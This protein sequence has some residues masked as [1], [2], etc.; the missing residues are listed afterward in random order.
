MLF[1][2]G[3]R[4]VCCLTAGYHDTKER[5]KCGP[6]TSLISGQR[7]SKRR[8]QVSQSQAYAQTNESHVLSQTLVKTLFRSM[9]CI[10][11]KKKTRKIWVS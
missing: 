8:R 11:H 4:S 1:E 6:F 3:S 10:Q 7:E 2:I 5:V 9:N